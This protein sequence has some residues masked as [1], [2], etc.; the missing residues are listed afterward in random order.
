VYFH[1]SNI[2]NATKSNNNN[3]NNNNNNMKFF[4]RFIWIFLGFCVT[5]TYGC[6]K[7]NTDPPRPSPRRTTTTPTTTT[8]TT[9]TP[10]TEPTSPPTYPTTASTTTTTTTERTTT[11]TTTT[12]IEQEAISGKHIGSTH[13]AEVHLLTQKCV[14]IF[15]VY[16]RACRFRK[17]QILNR[18]PELPLPT[19]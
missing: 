7:G 12:A 5:L 13:H 1:H 4:N 9:S 16:P 2:N 11:T 10:T 15:L 3:N 8:P 6:N 14:Q 19:L 18:S 17:H